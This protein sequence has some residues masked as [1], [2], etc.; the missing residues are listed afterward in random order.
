MVAIS[1]PIRAVIFSL[2]ATTL[3]DEARTTGIS[4]QTLKAVCMNE[5]PNSNCQDINKGGIK[6]TIVRLTRSCGPDTYFRAVAF[7]ETS[8]TTTLPDHLKKRAAEVDGTV[9][10][11]HHD[12]NFKQLRCDGGQLHFRADVSNHPGRLKLL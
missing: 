10:D 1:L 9:Y 4:I 11:L 8:N 7:R 3:M 12:W 5:G 6:G 2:S